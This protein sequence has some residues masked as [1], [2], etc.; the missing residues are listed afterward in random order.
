MSEKKS[1]PCKFGVPCKVPHKAIP[2]CLWKCCCP[3]C[4]VA[5]HEGIG[6]PLVGAFCCGWLYTQICWTPAGGVAPS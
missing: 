4:A 6:I 3:I 1:L 2:P 5:Y